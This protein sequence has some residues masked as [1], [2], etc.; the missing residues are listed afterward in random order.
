[1][2]A[3]ALVAGSNGSAIMSTRTRSACHKVQMAMLRGASIYVVRDHD[4]EN[5]SNRGNFFLQRGPDPL[6][7]AE[8]G[9]AH[10]GSLGTAHALI[11][12]IADAGAAAVKFQTHIAAEES[13]PSEPWRVAFSQQDRT[14]YDYWR[15]MEFSEDQWAGLREHAHSRGL[16]FISSPFSKAAVDLLVRVGVDALKIASGELAHVD[17]LRY[18]TS[19]R[20]PL[21]L[22]SGM[23]TWQELQEAV[24]TCRSED[25]QLC[26]MQCTSAYP[27]PPEWWG[28]NVIEQLSSRFGYPVGFSDHSGDIYAGLA[29]VAFGATVIEV[30]VALSK[31]AFGPDVA[32][33]LVPDQLAML[34]KGARDIDRAI[35]HPVDKDEKAAGLGDMRDLFTR[36]AVATEDLPAGTVIETHHLVAKKPGTGIPARAIDELIGRKLARSVESDQLL[37]WGDLLD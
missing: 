32:A 26:V 28:L 23:S 33:S 29:A 34:V 20:L 13:T 6:I 7:V 15:R 1:M 12:A 9:Q 30:H 22:S 10:D 8:V 5:Q 4:A 18:C 35:R 31:A 14:R 27:C 16:L 11:D 36:S 17:L 24:D 21:L 19:T 3:F 37:Q 2:A 25:S